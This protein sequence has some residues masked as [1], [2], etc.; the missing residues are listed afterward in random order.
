MPR[1][2]WKQKLNK[3]ERN[4]LKDMN[5]NTKY[6][7]EKQKEHIK[8]LIKQFPN[9]MPCWDCKHIFNKTRNVGGLK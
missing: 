4:H 1:K 2:T 9:T 5:I 7:L 3:R 6:D 8:K